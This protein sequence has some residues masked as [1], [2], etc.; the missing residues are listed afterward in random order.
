MELQK[1]MEGLVQVIFALEMPHVIL[2][3]QNLVDVG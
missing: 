3:M 1:G 2:Y